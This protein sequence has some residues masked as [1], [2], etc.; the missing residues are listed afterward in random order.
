MIQTL[1]EEFPVRLLCDLWDLAPSSYY[2]QPVEGD[3]LSLLVVIEEVLLAFPT[4]GYRRVAA[5]LGRRGHATN[6]KRVLRLMRRHDLM[7]IIRRRIQ[8]TD[9]GHSFP[10][11]PNLL[12]DCQVVRPDQAWCADI[13]YVRLRRGYVYLAIVL[14]VY[15]RSIRGWCLDSSL[16]SDLAM[17]ALRQALQSRRP[18]LHHSDQG[19]Q[20]AAT[21]YIAL[22]QAAGVQVSMS[23]P[24]R[25]TDNPYAER[26]MRT[27]KEEE[28]RLN[29]YEDLAHA[30]DC[31]GRF[32]DDVY[33][34][35]RVHS[36]LG[37]LTPAEFEAQWHRG[38]P[39]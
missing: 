14:D 31:I 8:T 30:R 25:P 32:I 19:V 17:T 35:K 28:V 7:R 23:A 37:Y 24:G 2:Y 29:E 4:Y 10:R 3:D 13:T 9:S 26:V 38:S 18:E 36:S 16:G 12:K 11:Y 21:G 5:E 34:T 22:L 27:I 6:R 1:A 20:Y 15:T 33:H 39:L